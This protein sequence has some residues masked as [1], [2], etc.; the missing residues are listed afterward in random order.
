MESPKP[1]NHHKNNYKDVEAIGFVNYILGKHRRAIPK[2]DAVDKWPNIDGT[3]ELQDV[4]NSLIGKFE[5]Q[6]KSLSKGHNYKYPIPVPFISYCDTVALL[7]V[8]FL[9]VDN[10]A[11]KVYWIY[12]NKGLIRNTNY[13]MNTT[14]VTVQIDK[15]NYF[16]KNNKNYLDDWEKILYQCKNTKIISDSISSFIIKGDKEGINRSEIKEI[17]L[18]TKEYENRNLI[19]QNTSFENNSLYLEGLKA[20]NN[21]E[22]IIKVNIYNAQYDLLLSNINLSVEK[23]SHREDGSI[24]VILSNKKQLSSFVFIKFKIVIK[25]MKVIS[26]KIN[27]S[28]MHKE[29]AFDQL[30]FLKF[31]STFD[32]TNK[33]LAYN[34]DDNKVFF[35]GVIGEQEM[36]HVSEDEIDYIQK[37]VDFPRVNNKILF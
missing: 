31:L 1:A 10:E 21:L 36:S 25:N 5:A 17:I 8:L 33:I 18:V 15:N 19:W 13:E 20:G 37:V 3:I 14:S 24:E 35:E 34:I 22:Q 29:R 30:T 23:R 32:K 2:L 16:D 27:A 28:A 11:E 12:M 9:L 4:K 26:T 6:V 7:P